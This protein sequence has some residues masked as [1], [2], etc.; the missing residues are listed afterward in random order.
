M[1]YTE[2]H[3]WLEDNNGIGTVGVTNHAQDQLGDIVYV[4][5]PKLGKVVK[6]GEEAAVLESTKAAAD[7]YTPVSG[8]IVEVNQGLTSAPELINRSPEKEGWIFKIK[9]SNKDEVK[10]LLDSQA[11]LSKLPKS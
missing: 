7:V 8:E 4:E 9:I 10:G 11:Y 1:K 5:L 2:T 3:E 6:I